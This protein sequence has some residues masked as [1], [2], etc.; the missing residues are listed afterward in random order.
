M[1]TRSFIHVLTLVCCT[2][3]CWSQENLFD[4]ARWKREGLIRATN[5][6]VQTT[7]APHP[8]NAQISAFHCER[9]SRWWGNLVVVR[10]DGDAM[11]GFVSLPADYL[12]N[13]GHYVR[14]ISWRKIREVGWV[15]QVLTST[16][17]G[18]GSLWL[19][20]IRDGKMCSLMNTRAVAENNER[21]FDHGQLQIEYM[22][23]DTS[24]PVIMRLHGTEHQLD[25]DG[26][27]SDKKVEAYWVWEASKRLF[28]PMK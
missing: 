22:D 12:E 16:H 24:K 5:S 27:Q 20:E 26:R 11:F 28:L 8:E 10:H 23:T 18:N 13:A 17:R 1:F 9:E 21:W 7:R 3:S 4:E 19:L 15:L 25:E 2:L 14:D 6:F